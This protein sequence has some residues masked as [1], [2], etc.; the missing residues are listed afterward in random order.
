MIRNETR[1]NKPL[2]GLPKIYASECK[3]CGQGGCLKI[4][5]LVCESKTGESGRTGGA[6][7]S[8]A[9]PA[10]RG[11]RLPPPAMDPE[12][13]ELER[14]KHVLFLEM[15]MERLPSDYET[16]EIN[17]LTLAYFAI[18]GLGILGALDR[19]KAFSFTNFPKF[20]WLYSFHAKRQDLVKNLDLLEVDHGFDNSSPFFVLRCTIEIDRSV[21]F[22]L[23]ADSHI[24]SKETNKNGKIKNKKKENFLCFSM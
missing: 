13:L 21:V 12:G 18:S 17:R 5:M 11:V 20:L 22:L 14:E 2:D 23:F 19:V 24:N 1:G 8:S 15:M 9:D 10:F 3:S 16:Q 7:A 4:R 6:C